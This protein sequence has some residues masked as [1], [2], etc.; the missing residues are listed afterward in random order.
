MALIRTAAA[1]MVAALVAVGCTEPVDDEGSAQ[2]NQTT[3]TPVPTTSAP[4]AQFEGMWSYELG[5][6][7]HEAELCGY[8][9]IEEPYVHVLATEAGWDPD[10]DPGLHRSDEGSLVYHWI[11]LPRSGTR[12]DP[13]TRSLW[14]WGE[15]PMTDGDHVSVGGASDGQLAGAYNLHQHNPW[16][17]NSMGPAERPC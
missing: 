10:I 14:V 12:Y 5:D 6:D 11:N 2:P 1:L 9:I 15:G 13:R 8:L 3:T 4:L 7:H 17:T 16:L